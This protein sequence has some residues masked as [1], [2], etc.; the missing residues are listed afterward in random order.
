MYLK[1]LFAILGFFVVAVIYYH[2][3]W[4]NILA[5]FVGDNAVYLLTTEYSSPY[6][7]SSAVAKQFAKASKY[8]PLY[9]AVL[10]LLGGGNSVLVAHLITTTSI[11]GDSDLRGGLVLFPSIR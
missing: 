10:A 3:I 5:G 9:P 4:S 11:I 1:Y 7:D 6:L 8:P 2:W